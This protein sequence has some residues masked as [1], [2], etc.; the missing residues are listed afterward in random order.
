MSI[1]S[2]IKNFFFPVPLPP[3]HFRVEAFD[4]YIMN[5]DDLQKEWNLHYSG[6]KPV[7]GI[8]GFCLPKTRKIYVCYSGDKDVNG[9]HMPLL[10]TTAHEIMHFNELFGLWHGKEQ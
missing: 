6:S 1:F 4:L 2:A 8:T 5:Y 10:S 3:K 9:N 7:S